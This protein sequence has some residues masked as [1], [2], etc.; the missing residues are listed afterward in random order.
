MEQSYT[1]RLLVQSLERSI[2][3]LVRL[4]KRLADANVDLGNLDKT[5]LGSIPSQL[6]VWDYVGSLIYGLLGA[7]LST[8]NQLRDFLD[9]VHSDASAEHPRSTLGAILHHYQDDIDKVPL[10]GQRVFLDRSGQQ[11]RVDFHR[12]LRGHDPF[13]LSADNPFLVLTT[14]PKYGIIKGV[15]Q[16]FR[17][18]AADTFS[19]QGLPIPFHSFFDYRTDDGKLSN[20]LIYIAER[21]KQTTGADLRANEVFSHLFSLKV[22]DIL[23][24]GLTWALCEAH[25]RARSIDDEIR[26]TQIRVVGYSSTFL[27]QV[28]IG[29]VRTGGVPMINWPTLTLLLKELYKFFR[30]NRREI[31]RLEAV[32][33][34]LCQKNLAL[35]AAVLQTGRALPTLSTGA[36]Y[37][38]ELERGYANIDSLTD[39]FEE[40]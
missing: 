19:K 27:S 22:Q 21:T 17:H 8:R 35:E 9:T 18:L 10:N 14:Q 12:L 34:D 3:D 15:I 36:D 32:T 28:V 4:Q 29:M 40:R 6:D 5:Q 23:S 13:S 31:R 24:T 37:I 38:R 30:L 16:V 11:A 1:D 25:I 26:A 33:E 20:W 2:Q 7:A 39:I